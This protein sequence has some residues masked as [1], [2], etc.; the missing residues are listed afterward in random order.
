MSDNYRRRGFGSFSL[1]PPV[2]K[3][4]IIINVVVFLCQVLF[5]DFYH[6]GD[7]SL[8]AYFFFYCALEPLGHGFYPWQLIT[9]QF[10]HG[11][12]WH[13]FF[14]LFALWMFGAE[15]E[16]LWGS[17]KFLI[18]Y[19]LSGIGAGLTQL[20]ISPLL[21]AS[22][23]TVGA[24]GA[25]FGILVAFALTFPNRP[26]FMFPLFIPIPAKYF[27]LGFAAL[28]IFSGFTSSDNVAYFAHLGGAAMGFLLF[29]YGDKI[30]IYRLFEKKR[31]GSGNYNNNPYNNNTFS[32]NSFSGF[33]SEPKKEA[34]IF[35][36]NWH[37]TRSKVDAYD[38]QP[39]TQ[40]SI[41]INGEEI[42]QSRIDEI[43]DKI[44]ASGYQNLTEKE[45]EILFELSQ[46]LK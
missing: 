26:I 23:P 25:I 43:L 28:Q 14:N 35:Q 20:Y 33:S 4:L 3:S 32:N 18:Y 44:S 6:I 27:V 24:S 21:G 29:K 30:G 2:L 34:G 42:T 7:I 1:F 8:R 16:T 10:M 12:L 36:S 45:K 37:T 39:K 22:G 15:L 9:Y 41:R 31:Q 13:I 19:L 38:N 46:K 11:G 17:R 5:F 40:H